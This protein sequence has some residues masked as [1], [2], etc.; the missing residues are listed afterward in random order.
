LNYRKLTGD[1]RWPANTAFNAA[2]GP[3]AGAFPI[4][5]LRTAK[6]DVVVGVELAKAEELDKRDERWRVSGK[7]ALISFVPRAA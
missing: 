3:I 1:I 7:Y 6:A 2:I 5:S 4:L